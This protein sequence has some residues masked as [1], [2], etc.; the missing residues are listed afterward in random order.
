LISGA[1]LFLAGLIIGSSSGSLAAS[2]L[3]SWIGTGIVILGAIVIFGSLLLLLLPGLIRLEISSEG[4][5]I[6]NFNVR[7]HYSWNELDEFHVYTL[8]PFLPYSSFVV[9][10]LTSERSKT[11]PGS[12][13]AR[14]IFKGEILLMDTYGQSATG[15]A[16]LLK[17]SREALRVAS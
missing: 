3:S 6:F 7:Q 14:R 13:F 12:E 11:L 5:T 10:Q 16:K 2:S 1:L 8:I 15:L 17:A 4:I 9:I